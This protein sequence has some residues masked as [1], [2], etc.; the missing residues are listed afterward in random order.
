MARES[1][2]FLATIYKIWIMRHVDVPADIAMALIG[3]M[4]RGGAGRKQAAPK[5]IPVVATVNRKSVKTTL[6]PSGAGR[7]RLT[8]NT[9][10][11]KAGCADT[12][13]VI[14]VA[15]KF[16]PNSREVAA[17]PEYLE[18]LKRNAL[19][20]KEFDQLPPG[21]R[22]QLLAYYLK[23]KS[24]SARVRAI[25]KTIDHLRERALMRPPATKRCPTKPRRTKAWKV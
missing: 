15:L 17:P 7:Y 8:L 10:L 11:R 18:A 19:A 24:P 1:K 22:R 2:Q 21:H 9:A 5:H 4:R 13:D 25:E 12:G 3:E 16:D 14:G 6:A 20:K 23:T